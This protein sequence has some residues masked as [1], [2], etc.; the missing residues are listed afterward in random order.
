MSFF[1]VK[2]VYKDVAMK[3][4]VS[5]CIFIYITLIFIINVISAKFIFYFI[6]R[7]NKNKTYQQKLMEFKSQYRNKDIANNAGLISAKNTD[8]HIFRNR[9]KIKIN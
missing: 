1:K 8:S 9:K 7:N 6:N 2:W 4:L 5:L 3:K